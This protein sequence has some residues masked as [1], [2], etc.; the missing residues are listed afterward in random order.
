MSIEIIRD[1]IL[2]AI[3]AQKEAIKHGK[4][5]VPYTPKSDARNV[6]NLT[7]DM[8]EPERIKIGKEY[9]R[10]ILSKLNKYGEIEP[11]SHQEDIKFKLDGF[12]TLKTP[13]FGDL[14]GKRVSVQ[15]KKRSQSGDDILFEIER[16]FDNKTIG[17]D[18]QG[19]ATLYIVSDRSGKIG[20]FRTSRLKAIIT[21]LLNKDINSL[22][23]FRKT[24]SKYG[25]VTNIE[26]GY[27]KAELRVTQGN[28]RFNEGDRKLIAFINFEAGAPLVV[29]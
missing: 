3:R 4:K 10:E 13:E 26:S 23:S 17:R 11:S 19:T 5:F 8:E 12:I 21:K 28:S 14:I 27:K 2:K 7:K 25:L 1:S 9:E 20:I 24:Y 22:E 18:Q 16:D 15:I 6:K 29:L